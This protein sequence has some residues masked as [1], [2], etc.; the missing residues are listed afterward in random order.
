MFGTVRPDRPE[1]AMQDTMTP[2]ETAMA[3]LFYPPQKGD[4]QDGTTFFNHRKLDVYF[5]YPVDYRQAD[6]SSFS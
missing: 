1:L 4:N 5:Q 3:I 2:L 6:T